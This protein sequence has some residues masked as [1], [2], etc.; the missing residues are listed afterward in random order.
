MAWTTEMYQGHPGRY[1]WQLN[2]ADIQ[3][4]ENAMKH[5]KGRVVQARRDAVNS[6]S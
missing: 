3:E 1:Q 4:I 6:C 5:F 2:D